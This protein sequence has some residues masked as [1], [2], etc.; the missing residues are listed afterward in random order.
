MVRDLEIGMR[1]RPRVSRMSLS[2]L[3]RLTLEAVQTSSVIADA[4][5]SEIVIVV[6]AGM[7]EVQLIVRAEPVIHVASPVSTAVIEYLVGGLLDGSPPGLDGSPPLPLPGFVQTFPDKLH[8][9]EQ[10]GLVANTFSPE[11]FTM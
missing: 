9:L 5:R 3:A 2:S 7:F 4:A 1:W 6:E 8:V 11:F 10:L